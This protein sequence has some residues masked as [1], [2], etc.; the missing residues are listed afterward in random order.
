[1]NLGC[2]AELYYEDFADETFG[3]GSNIDVLRELA[4]TRPEDL[5]DDNWKMI[6]KDALT[7]KSLCADELC[8]ITAL[9]FYKI[10]KLL[11]LLFLSS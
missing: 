1:M 4:R 3:N 8:A 5:T 7:L 9:P 2:E 11:F 6:I 10:S